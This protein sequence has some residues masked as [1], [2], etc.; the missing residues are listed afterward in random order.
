M[1]GGLAV[2]AECH[3]AAALYR[4]VLPGHPL[5]GRL[6]ERLGRGAG[7]SLE[8]MDFRNYVPGDDLRHVDWQAY[9]RTGQLTVRL[10]REETAPS[11]D[12]IADTTRSMGVTEGKARALLDLV[13]AAAE[14]SARAGGVARRLAAGGDVLPDGSE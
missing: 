6:G 7:S 10:F 11:L 8:F 12:V 14:W 9:A 13:D 5:A 1:S 4:L 3:Q 2:R